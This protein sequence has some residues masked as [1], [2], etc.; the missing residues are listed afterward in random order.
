MFALHTACIEFCFVVNING[1]HF[2]IKSDGKKERN[3]KIWS[4]ACSNVLW[5]GEL[6]S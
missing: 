1:V 6:N 2:G 4:P 5:L 3:S